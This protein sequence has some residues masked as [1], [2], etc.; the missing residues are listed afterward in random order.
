[1]SK[2]EIVYEVDKTT[3]H[4]YNTFVSSKF[5][6]IK[7]REK[8]GDSKEALGKRLRQLRRKQGLTLRELGD[9]IGKSESY[10]SRVE[11]GR[12]DLSLSTLKEIADQF[13][14][15]IAHLLDNGFPPTDELIKKGEHHKLVISPVLEYDILCSSNQE[16]SFF[17]MILKEGGNS[18]DKPYRHHGIEGGI[19]LKGRVRIVVGDREYI[20]KE[21]DSLTYRSEQPHWFENAGKG[22]A[23]AIWAVAPATF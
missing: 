2:A 5:F 20:L 6:S 22:D 17:R 12:I 10:L 4:S 15:P 13:G 19:M 18:G 9:R 16:I 14:R 11:R 1:M 23:I 8:M 3:P 21:G 7:G